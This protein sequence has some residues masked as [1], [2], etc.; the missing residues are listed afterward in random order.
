MVL[1]HIVRILGSPVI[2]PNPIK[3]PDLMDALIEWIVANAA[4]YPVELAAE[5]HY[6]FVTI[7]PFVDGNGRTGRLLMNLILMQNGYPPAIIRTRDRM[8]YIGGLEKA[9]LGGS[10]DGYNQLIAA[11]VDCSL[12][13]YL[14][15]ARGEVAAAADE[16]EPDLLRIGQLARDTGESNATIRYWTKEGLLQVAD[17]TGSGYQLYHPSM[18]DRVSRIRKLQ[19]QGLTLKEIKGEL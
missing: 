14:K 7:H 3:V 16:R 8:Q 5:V 1:N 9:Q 6:Q 13:I 10:R 2:V 11:A 15:A 4:L 17:T 19:G 12:D 18:I